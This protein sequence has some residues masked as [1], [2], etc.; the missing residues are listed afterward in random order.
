MSGAGPTQPAW[1]P[2]RD[3]PATAFALTF[4]LVLTWVYLVVFGSSGDGPVEASWPVRISYGVGKSIQ[5]GFPLLYVWLF[6]PARLRPSRPTAEGMALGL[7][8]G[9]LVAFAMMGVYFGLLADS[10]WFAATPGK[11]YRLLQDTGLTTP[12]RYGLLAVFYALAH[13]LL[14]EYYWRWFVFDRLRRGTPLWIAIATS[15][16]G[17]MAH[18]VVLLGVYFPGHFWELAMPLSLGVALGGGVWAWIYQR[19]GSIYAVWLSHAIVDAAI[20]TIG[21]AM[22]APR[23]G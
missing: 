13:S 11:V 4:P 1:T 3:I 21:Y 19:T 6:D 15:A 2:G 8:F 10:P 16:L 17:F 9:L 7:G 20:F 23:L 14:E 18:H 12:L 22:V 5:F